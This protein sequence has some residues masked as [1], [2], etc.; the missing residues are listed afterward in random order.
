[1]PTI[2]QV[3]KRGRFIKRNKEGDQLYS[4]KGVEFVI[5]GEH[6]QSRKQQRREFGNA[7]S[8]FP[9]KFKQWL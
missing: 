2:E 1:M 4:L 7:A 8:S 6:V 3:R 5:I 9:Y